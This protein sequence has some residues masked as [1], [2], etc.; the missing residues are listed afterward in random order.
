MFRSNRSDLLKVTAGRQTSPSVKAFQ[1]NHGIFRTRA[2]RGCLSP[3]T[4]HIV[5]RDSP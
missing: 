1:S 3:A 5:D 4:T 2:G